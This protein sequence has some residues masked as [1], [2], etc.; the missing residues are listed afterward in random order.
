MATDITPRSN[1]HLI[2]HE[3][4]AQQLLHDLENGKLAHG[5][6]ITGPRGIGK[7]TFAYCFARTLLG[8]PADDADHP[9]NRR[10]IAGSHADLLVLE[11]LYDGKKDEYVREISVD[12]ARGISQFLSLTS[13]EGQWRVVIID[14]VDALG[15]SAANA[16]LKILEEPPPRTVLM[17]ISHAPGRLLPTIRS[18]CRTV[19]IPPLSPDQ[20]T[21]VMRHVCP[22]LEGSEI[23]ALAQLSAYSPGVALEIYEQGGIALYEQLIDLLVTLPSLD[24]RAVHGLAE[25]IGTGKVHSN[26][27]LFTQLILSL[28]SRIVMMGEGGTIQ[29]ICS[30]EPDALEHLSRLQPSAVWAEKWQQVADEFSL[31]QRLHLDY[32][33]AV[34]T[35]IHSIPTTEGF[36]LGI[37][38]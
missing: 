33:Q 19:K 6:L 25:Q 13:G 29:P 38:A 26:W 35:F 8:A 30:N 2:G 20:F 1:I 17:L 22:T 9:V 18:R 27:Q 4:A 7:A 11:P 12:Q 37:A 32:K 36:H 16:I 24:F 23:K 15:T 28:F 31:A 34:I 3:N 5:L 10:I 21:S 14:P